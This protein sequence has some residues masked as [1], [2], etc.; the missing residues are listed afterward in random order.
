MLKQY[1][2]IIL[3]FI[4]GRSGYA[5]S[6]VL[7]AGIRLQKAIG[8]YSEN[9][10]TLNYSN[11][12]YSPDKLYLGFSYYT[13]RLG[14]AY[15]SNAIKQDN[16]L[17]SAAWY[18]RHSKIIRPFTRLNV[19]YFSAD[20]GSPIFDVLPSKSALL[21]ADGGLCFQTHS[22]LKLSA[23][24]GYNFITGNGINNVP[25]TIYPFFYQLTAS[26]NILK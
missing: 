23:S 2:I 24:L 1:S 11:K 18:F 26:W 17:L 4:A 14:T 9:G 13:S 12:N 25:G 5:Q 20:Y 6:S 3:L 21:S 8:L 15:H 22:P 16:Y 10:F 7:D 19:G